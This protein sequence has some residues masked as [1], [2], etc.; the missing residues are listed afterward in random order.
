MC[1]VRLLLKR[2]KLANWKGIELTA[3]RKGDQVKVTIDGTIQSDDSQ[4]DACHKIKDGNGFNHYIFLRSGSDYGDSCTVETVKKA[5]SFTAGK[6]Y[7]DSDGDVCIRTPDGW[8][9]SNGR[10]HSDGW[11]TRPVKP[12][13]EAT[14]L[15]DLDI[16]AALR[17]AARS[18]GVLISA[19]TYDIMVA[20]L[21]SAGVK[22][23]G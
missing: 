7:V 2:Q 8:I 9:D 20:E 21:K 3:Y 15:T 6:A 23:A 19:S 10:N 22:V 13:E 18:R 11:A 4:H 1:L 12:L 16:K 5:E 14:T 17:K